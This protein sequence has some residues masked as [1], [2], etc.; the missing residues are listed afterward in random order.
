MT[1]VVPIE[2]DIPQQVQTEP[3]EQHQTTVDTRAVRLPWKRPDLRV[4]LVSKFSPK[5]EG[6]VEYFCNLAKSVSNLCPTVG[7][8]NVD[9]DAPPKEPNSRLGMM[10]VWRLNSVTYPFRILKA[11]ICQKP[12]VV[13]VNHEYMMYGRPFY[14][15]FMPLLLLLLRLAR[16]PIVLTMHSVVAQ[17]S[18]WNGFFKRY[19]S[20]RLAPLKTIFFIAWTRLTLRFASRILVHS[21]ASK[22]I[23]AD[24][25]GYPDDRITVIGHGIEQPLMMSRSGAKEILGFEGKKVI[26]NFGY[27]HPKKGIEYLI[28]A[29]GDVSRTHPDTILVIAGGPH[30]SHTADPHEFH[31]YLQK[32]TH[33]INEVDAERSVVLRAEYIPDD[34]ISLYFSSADIVAL[35]YIEQFGTSGVLARAMA[36]GRAV[37]ATRV[38]P[39]F[40]VIEDGVNGLLVDPANPD[41]L[42]NA[43]I[44]LLQDS[45][46]RDSLGNNLKNSGRALQWPDIAMMHV[47]VY[48][49]LSEN[50]GAPRA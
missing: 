22:R 46:L 25:Y 37:I 41:Q 45:S 10:R 19:G 9:P 31:Q 12:N 30:V 15:A 49:S 50:H 1:E 23:L 11:C 21:Q 39:F 26:L 14:G 3:A 42:S 4:V 32:L 8:A 24:E 17:R 27:I 28:R 16:R 34:L 5:R 35:P 48:S 2:L 40:E 43:I 20:R 7:I 36:A 44:R 38:N 29:M 33:T 47:E 6:G 13:H 18:V